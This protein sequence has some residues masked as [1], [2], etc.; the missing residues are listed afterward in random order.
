MSKFRHMRLVQP[1]AVPAAGTDVCRNTGCSCVIDDELGFCAECRYDYE[2][3]RAQTE[4]RD[5]QAQQRVRWALPE[6]FAKLTHS[7]H[8][9]DLLAVHLAANADDSAAIRSL[10]L[11]GLDDFLADAQARRHG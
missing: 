3:A 7:P 6:L 4:E 11:A 10:S 5:E 1:S 8:L 2:M 9:A